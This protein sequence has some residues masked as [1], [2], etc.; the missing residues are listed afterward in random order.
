MESPTCPICRTP[1]RVAGRTERCDQCEGA[2]IHEDALVGILEARA[3][4]LVELPWQ[5]RPK[6]QER[7]CAVCGSAMQTVSL[8]SV[9]LDRCEQHGVWFD[10]DEL[11]AL[12]KQAKKF[13]A[14]QPDLKK[15]EPHE[16]HGLLHRIAH[17]FGRDD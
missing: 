17:L 11:A 3:A 10:A 15:A 8:G 7:P 12:L 14:S 16:H 6:D 5:A 2:W 1:L 9:A 13:R 4:T